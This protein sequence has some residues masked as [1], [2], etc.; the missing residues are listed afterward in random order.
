MISATTARAGTLAE[1]WRRGLCGTTTGRS[2]LS[3]RDKVRLLPNR[4][5]AEEAQLVT[6]PRVVELE[7]QPDT[8]ERFRACSAEPWCVLLDS[9]H[10]GSRRGRYDMFSASPYLTIETRGEISEITT[11]S[12]SE[13]SYEEPLEL[14]RNGLGERVAKRNEL[15]FEGGAI[16]YFGYDLGRRFERLPHLAQRDI[17]MPDMAVGFYD[18]VVVVDHQKRRAWLAGQGRDERTCDLWPDIVERVSTLPDA[19]ATEPFRVVSPVVSNFDR[20][21]Y[22]DAFDRVQKHI[23]VGDCYQVN[24]AQRFSAEVR[25]SS[26]NA[27][28]RLRELNPAPFAAYLSTPAGDVLSS[29]PERFLRV[30]GGQVE[31]RPIKGT[32]PRVLSAQRDAE[33]AD[34]LSNSSKDRAE[35]VMIVDLLRNDLGK[36]CAP[37]TVVVD[38]ICDVESYANVHHLVSTVRGTL[39]PDSHALDLLRGCFPGGSITGAP[40]VR[41]MEIIESLEPHRRGVYCGAIGYIGFDGE[42]DTNIAIRTLVRHENRIYA[43]A[44]GGIVADSDPEAEYQEGL[45]KVET[46]LAIMKQGIDRRT[47]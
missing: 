28:E 20:E 31:T 30:T 4:S 12:T 40:K 8:V 9:G 25:G 14:L 3:E 33:L 18:W 44:G 29:S 23:R 35:N 46:Q 26:W 36:S 45:A 24:L 16:G 38:S 21:T 15:P 41:A 34:E 47:A 39:A 43:W 17:D 6:F 2:E 37:G 32:R 42:M 11:R 10:P 13:C 22:G 7:Y 27:Y 5:S 1:P 19:P